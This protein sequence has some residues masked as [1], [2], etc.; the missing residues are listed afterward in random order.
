MAYDGVL[1]Y[2]VTREL[3]SKLVGGRINKIQQPDKDEIHI[4]IRSKG[5]NYKLLLSASANYPRIHLSRHTKTNP[6]V[7]PV[8]CMVL[9]KHLLGGKLISIHQPNM[10]RILELNFEVIDE[11]GDLQVKKIIIEIM[12]KHSNIILTGAKGLILDAIKHVNSNISRVREVFPGIPYVSPPSKNKLDPFKVHISDV[13]NKLQTHE[14]RFQPA[15]IIVKSFFGISKIT[16][17]EICHRAYNHITEKYADSAYKCIGKVSIENIAIS[18][19][20]FFQEMVHNKFQPTI[21]LD[22]ENKLKDIFPMR[23]TM[24][25]SELLKS[26][27]SISDALD[28]FYFIRDQ[29]ER[30]QQRS[31]QLSRVVRNNLE[32]CRN[33]L[34]K[35]IDALERAKKLEQYRLYGELITANIYQI[36]KGAKEIVLTNYYEPESPM[37]LIPLQPDKTPVQNAQIYFKQYNKAKTI[38]EKHSQLIEETNNELEYLESILHYLSAC[39]NESD[40]IDIHEELIRE[41]YLKN[42]SK[43]E[44]KRKKNISKPHRFLSSDGLEIL[45]GKNNTQNDQLTFKTAAPY[46]IWLHTKAVHGSH[47]IIKTNKQPVPET[48]LKEAANL[49]VYFSKGR[50]S[51][52][53]PVDYC[54]K[55]YVKKPK[56][57]KPGM[58][59]YDN[60]KTIYITPSEDMLFPMR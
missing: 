14:S 54:Y 51:S 40:I 57:A 1:L 29:K 6:L 28:D 17:E 4:T 33:K 7:P 9:R 13:V 5:N 46:N 41:G 48:T 36:P 56:G 58:V 38:L 44:N 21:L 55:K 26:Y 3:E 15:D 31:S 24:F 20:R 2:C 37:V 43:S 16:A 8:F 12:G 39:I 52:N 60:F 47:V 35:Q 11:M 50:N 49:A 42:K 25:H 18:F 23:Y 22:E 10:D 53:V 27:N 45:V 19:M 59:I 34:Q 32:R 30:I